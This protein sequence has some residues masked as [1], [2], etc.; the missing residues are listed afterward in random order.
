V[1]GLLDMSG[2]EEQI[3][4]GIGLHVAQLYAEE[5]EEN[6]GALVVLDVVSQS[7]AAIAGIRPG[8]C[9]THIDG[10]SAHGVP[11]SELVT[12]R[13]RGSLGT[14]MRL[15]ISRLTEEAFEIQLNRNLSLAV[16]DR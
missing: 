1:L 2:R 6:R 5:C 15:K 11:F 10:V 7:P 13:L 3:G 16:F 4:G 12:K 9:V 8:D 14:Q